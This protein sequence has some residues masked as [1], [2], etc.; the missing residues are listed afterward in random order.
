VADGNYDRALR[1]GV[2]NSASVAGAADA[3]SGLLQREA[4][5]QRVAQAGHQDSIQRWSLE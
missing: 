1:A 2:I 5:D 4:L 3:H